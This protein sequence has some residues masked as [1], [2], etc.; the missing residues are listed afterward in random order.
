M[1]SNDE[2][3]PGLDTELDEAFR[4][5]SGT[6]EAPATLEE[7]V[8]EQLPERPEPQNE[9][10][11]LAPPTNIEIIN[12]EILATRDLAELETLLK[13]RAD[14]IQEWLK[15]RSG[16]ARKQIQEVA[17]E[18]TQQVTSV[19]VLTKAKNILSQGSP[20]AEDAI[21]EI[22][23]S[24]AP[25][26]EK[27]QMRQSLNEKILQQAE[28]ILGQGSP[29][30]DDAVEHIKSHGFPEQ[31]AEKMLKVLDEK[32]LQQAKN[33]LGQ[34]SPYAEDASSHIESSAAL[35][36]VAKYMHQALDAQ[37]VRQAKNIKGQGTPYF[38]DAKQ[39]IEEN[40]TDTCRD[41]AIEVL[42]L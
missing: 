35:P 3:Y 11:F 36:L 22:D 40:T 42:G 4:R 27:E 39:H 38:E 15:A 34:G 29:Y 32:V 14:I 28:N 8:R 1:A 6:D 19:Q 7:V 37:I 20:Y 10:I 33:I 30:I 2:L 13:N 5:H 23:E 26:V 41:K 16:L 12:Q 18:V 24:A 25:P 31:E 17:A 9:D 21:A